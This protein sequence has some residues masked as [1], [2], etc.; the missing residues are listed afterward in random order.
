MLRDRLP[1]LRLGSC[2]WDRAAWLRGWVPSLQRRSRP[3]RCNHFSGEAT[4]KGVSWRSRLGLLPPPYRIRAM[5]L[6]VTADAL[7]ADGT[8]PCGV[9]RR[10]AL[11]PTSFRKSDPCCP[12]E[13]RFPPL[14][15]GLDFL[16]GLAR[17]VHRHEEPAYRHNC[18]DDLRDACDSAHIALA[19]HR[20]QTALRAGSDARPS[21]HAVGGCNRAAP[22]AT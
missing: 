17:V 15:V 10:I 8:S 5:P 7:S 1:G 13:W 22:L 4:K 12:P 16:E 11:V 20:S 21:G 19:W 2:E 14:P 9:P 6:A 18:D 3:P